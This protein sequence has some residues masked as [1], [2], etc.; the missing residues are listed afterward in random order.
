MRKNFNTSALWSAYNYAKN[1]A[2]N[3]PDTEPEYVDRALGMIM[4][5]KY[6]EKVDQYN[7]TKDRCHCPTRHVRV[8]KHQVMVMVTIKHD[9]IM[10]EEIWQEAA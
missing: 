10:E 2:R 4:A 5:G 7:T 8:C 3:N 1:W 9:Q 6:D